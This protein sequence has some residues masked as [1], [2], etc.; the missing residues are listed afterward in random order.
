MSTIFTK[1]IQ[2]QIPSYKIFEDDKTFA[3]LDIR[4]HNLGHTLLVPK[5]EIDSFENLTDELRNQIFKNAQ[6]LSRVI[7]K[8]TTAKRVGLMIHGMGIPDHFHL[9]LVPMFSAS[10]TDQSKAHDETSQKMQE[11]QQKILTE[12]EKMS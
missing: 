6:F 1:I 5:T 12:I 7:K 3:F 9:H 4:P 11:I 10:D 8:A 2:N